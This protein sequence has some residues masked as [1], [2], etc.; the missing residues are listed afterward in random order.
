[1]SLLND[2][3]SAAGNATQQV[4]DTARS[5][6]RQFDDTAGGGFADELA[7]IA[8]P[9]RRTSEE[10][11]SDLRGG[12]R[13]AQLLSP[14][15]GF[16]NVGLSL[17]DY[18]DTQA[19]RTPP[20]SDPNAEPDDEKTNPDTP[21]SAGFWDRVFRGNTP[22]EQAGEEADRA[23]DWARSQAFDSPYITIA[24]I[25]I[26]LLVVLYLV[27]PLLTIGANLSG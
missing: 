7:E 13:V 1:M 14:T 3:Q 2:I 6:P 24:V 25:G 27:R 17:S 19:G 22:G 5:V 26:I 20:G 9:T 10:T 12:A 16:A 8:D 11:E 23:A 15:A 4:Q 18:L 21:A